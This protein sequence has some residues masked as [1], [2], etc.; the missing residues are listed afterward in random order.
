VR[1]PAN[2]KVLDMCSFFGHN[3][4]SPICPKLLCHKDDSISVERMTVSTSTVL[5][6]LILLQYPITSVNPGDIRDFNDAPPSWRFSYDGN[7]ARAFLAATHKIPLGPQAR[8]E[9]FDAYLL[10]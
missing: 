4:R 10:R 9:N 1:S 5:S 8:V 2:S 3:V 7:E 6:V